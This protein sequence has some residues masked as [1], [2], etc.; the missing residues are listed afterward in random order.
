MSH[1]EPPA[2]PL[3]QRPTAIRS[4]GARFVAQ[5]A[6]DASSKAAAML[7]AERSLKNRLAEAI[8]ASE[9]RSLVA[10]AEAESLRERHARIR[11]R[12]RRLRAWSVLDMR[13]S[14]CATVRACAR[15]RAGSGMRAQRPLVIA[16][17]PLRLGRRV[18][19]CGCARKGCAAQGSVAQASKSIVPFRWLTLRAST[20]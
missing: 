6:Q 16:P 20:G 17:I 18:R 9:A 15:T 7:E 3:A 10:V 2:R 8:G 13:T 5:E 14:D 1:G 12:S 11:I 19:P 4:V